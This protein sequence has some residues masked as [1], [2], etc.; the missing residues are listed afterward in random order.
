MAVT[1]GQY[2]SRGRLQLRT[3]ALEQ[4]QAQLLHLG[5]IH[6][7]AGRMTQSGQLFTQRLELTEGTRIATEP[8]SHFKQRCHRAFL[9]LN[10]SRR[11][12]VVLPLQVTHQDIAPWR[13]GGAE[14]H[15]LAPF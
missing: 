5:P 9:W 3:V 12:Q 14:G 8:D 7:R 15:S 11:R 13:Q 6:I 4:R 10:S 1:T 2:E